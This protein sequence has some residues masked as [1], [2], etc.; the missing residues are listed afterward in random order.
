MALTPKA[1]TLKNLPLSRVSHQASVRPS[2]F[3]IATKPRGNP[4]R[5]KS[6]SPAQFR[7]AIVGAIVGP[8][9]QRR[10]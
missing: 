5:W 9:K 8:P 6:K 2:S 1:L 10:A 3:F 7:A 4:K